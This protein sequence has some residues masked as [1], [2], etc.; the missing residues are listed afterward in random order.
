MNNTKNVNI[1][2]RSDVSRHHG[3][4]QLRAHETPQLRASETAQLR[5]SEG[6]QTRSNFAAQ[7]LHATLLRNLSKVT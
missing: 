5:A 6:G 4:A 1:L 2:R 7:P 3:G